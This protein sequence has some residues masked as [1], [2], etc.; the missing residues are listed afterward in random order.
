MDGKQ[1]PEHNQFGIARVDC[2]QHD[3]FLSTRSDSAPI[4]GG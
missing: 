1:I 4:M 3:D 2:W